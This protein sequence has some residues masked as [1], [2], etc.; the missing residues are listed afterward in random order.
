[1][2][3]ILVQINESSTDAVSQGNISERMI[4][5]SREGESLWYKTTLGDFRKILS[6]IALNDDDGSVLGLDSN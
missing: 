6:D 4:S 3:K 1:M 2:A 5:Y